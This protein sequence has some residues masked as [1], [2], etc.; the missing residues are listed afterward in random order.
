MEGAMKALVDRSACIS[1]LCSLGEEQISKLEKEDALHARRH[2]CVN[3]P[4]KCFVL[5]IKFFV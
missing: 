2:Y 4:G 3:H 1:A 5:L